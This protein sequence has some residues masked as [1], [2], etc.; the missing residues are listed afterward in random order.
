VINVTGGR[1][2]KPSRP[3]LQAR[4]HHRQR[5][6]FCPHRL[7][8]TGADRTETPFTVS[9][10][11]AATQLRHFPA[12][13]ETI[14]RLARDSCLICLALSFLELLF[15][16]RPVSVI[17]RDEES[18]GQSATSPVWTRDSSSLGMT[19]RRVSSNRGLQHAR[20]VVEIDRACCF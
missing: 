2:L 8:R 10:F 14:L 12:R 4:C 17:P 7:A 9:L 3:N 16:L 18:L 13:S 11:F 19:R 6:L 5:V 15:S 1:R 20:S